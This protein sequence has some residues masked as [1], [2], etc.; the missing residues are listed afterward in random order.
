MHARVCSIIS[1]QMQSKIEIHR[2]SDRR[3]RRRDKPVK[4]KNPLSS[5]TKAAD[6]TDPDG[7]HVVFRLLD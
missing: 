5:Q 2:R 3:E 1:D 6:R 4:T 7:R